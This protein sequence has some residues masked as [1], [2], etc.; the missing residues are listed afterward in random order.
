MVDGLEMIVIRIRG[1][2]FLLH[3]IR[4]LI[5]SA[6]LVV[7]GIM[8]STAIPAAFLLPFHINFPLAPAEGLILVDAGFSRNANGKTVSINGVAGKD[9]DYVLMEAD[10]FERSEEFKR[11]KIYPKVATD[12]A[13]ESG[14]LGSTFLSYIERFRVPTYVEAEWRGLAQTY[15]NAQEAENELRDKREAAR[16]YREVI[17]FR[18]ELLAHDEDFKAFFYLAEADEG[19][20]S[21][22]KK[23]TQVIPHK[24]LLPNSLATDLVIHYCVQPSS[25]HVKDALRALATK[26]VTAT[27]ADDISPSMSNKEIIAFMES[28]GTLEHWASLKKHSMIE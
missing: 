21:P 16:I 18:R 28:K 4:L 1:Q 24:K 27:G 5:G 9:A 23:R 10:E 26:M 11:D 12:W 20:G 17:F 19:G 3:Q 25:V 15:Q 7:R 13:R 8:P 6:L 14:L 22:S 2:A